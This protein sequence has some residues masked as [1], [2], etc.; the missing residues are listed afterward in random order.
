MTPFFNP[1]FHSGKDLR[2]RDIGW[3]RTVS[4]F[5]WWFARA[6]VSVPDRTLAREQQLP[7]GF[8]GS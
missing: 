5:R 8:H 3:P 4:G 6:S 2:S 1:P 7:R